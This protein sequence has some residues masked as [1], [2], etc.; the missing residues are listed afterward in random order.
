MNTQINIGF[1]DVSFKPRVTKDYIVVEI[2]NKKRH[3][4]RHAV[5]YRRWCPLWWHGSRCVETVLDK[6]YLEIGDGRVF[7]S[8]VMTPLFKSVSDLDTGETRLFP[9]IQNHEIMVFHHL[10][11]LRQT[12]WDIDRESWHINRVVFTANISELCVHVFVQKVRS[13]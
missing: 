4:L 5:V 11:P 9:D 10:F 3:H 2:H 12:L 8:E 1:E 13:T 6:Q 7:V